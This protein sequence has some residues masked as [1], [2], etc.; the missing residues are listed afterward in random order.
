MY[1]IHFVWLFVCSWFCFYDVYYVGLCLC[2]RFFFSCFT[3][4]SLD[5]DGS[6]QTTLEPKMNMDTR[7][8]RIVINILHTSHT[9]WEIEPV[10]GQIHSLSDQVPK[11]WRQKTKYW[12]WKLYRKKRTNEQMLNSR[13]HQLFYDPRKSAEWYTYS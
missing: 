11:V 12:L 9:I 6:T 3:H 2:M 13:L 4:S 10:F 7:W 1:I 8:Q 5:I